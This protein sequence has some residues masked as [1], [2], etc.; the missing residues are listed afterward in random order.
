M[1]KT[2]IKKKKRKNKKNV[3]NLSVLIPWKYLGN[4]LLI[5]KKILKYNKKYDLEN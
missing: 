3:N 1:N 2:E 5:C 4:C